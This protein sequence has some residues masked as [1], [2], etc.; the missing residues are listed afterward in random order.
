MITGIISLI[1]D[2]FFLNNV[3]YYIDNVIVFPMFTL[4]FLLS[5]IFFNKDIKIILLIFFFN[6]IIN[7]TLFITLLIL[8]IN[9]YLKDKKNNEFYLITICM[10]LIL[11]DLFKKIEI[12]ESL[13][14]E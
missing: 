11:Y 8:L 12:W 10:S 14:I 4:V 13:K 2:Y 7:G 5:S 3:G 1:L 6:I 9:Y